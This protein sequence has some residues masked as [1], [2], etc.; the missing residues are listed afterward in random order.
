MMANLKGF[1]ES[2][3]NY[4]KETLKFSTIKKLRELKEKYPDDFKMEIV[5]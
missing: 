5:T 4:K 2:M 3:V 1:I